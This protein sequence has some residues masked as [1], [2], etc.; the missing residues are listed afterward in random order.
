[1]TDE[2]S[3]SKNAETGIA[4]ESSTNV[5][6]EEQKLIA[7]TEG[8]VCDAWEKYIM[9]SD[10]KALAECV[11]L[12]R[13]D[14]RPSYYNERNGEIRE[15]RVILDAV[16]KVLGECILKNPGGRKDWKKLETH[17]AINDLMFPGILASLQ[18]QLG[19][20]N[21]TR[22]ENI[23][24]HQARLRYAEKTNQTFDAVV[25]QDEAGGKLYSSD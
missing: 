4:T 23:T 5:N 19:I 15:E 22:S 25:K 7:H 18:S 11:R 24:R 16:L 8:M 9:D 14:I 6:D 10:P 3:S 1:M 12:L 13:G 21:S 17:R 2:R 20:N